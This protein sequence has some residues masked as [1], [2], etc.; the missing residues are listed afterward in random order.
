MRLVLALVAVCL[1]A[2]PHLYEHVATLPSIVD[3]QPLRTFTY[4]P[5]LNRFYAGSD[6]GLF[7]ADLSEPEPRLKGPVVK[8]DIVRIEMAPNLG[9]LFYVAYD[10]I[11][12]IDMRAPEQPVRIGGREQ[13]LDLA[14]EPDRQELYVST[15]APVMQVFDARSGERGPAIE[16]PGWFAQELEAVPGR[17]FFT[18]SSRQGVYAIDA[19]THRAA[20]WPLKERVVTPAHLE[21]DPAGRY[22]FIANARTIY[23]T[24]ASSGLVIGRAGTPWPAAIAFDPAADLLVACWNFDPPP[25]RIAAFKVDQHGL[26]EVG[27]LVNP[28]IGRVG[29]ESIS[30]GFI[31]SGYKALLVWRAK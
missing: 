9:R 23:A 5:V 19:A 17:V 7:W 22:L 6:R 30:R 21:A 26:T 4:D 16:L 2:Q 29:L 11:G 14:Y 31:Q 18:M 3:G 24:D 20:L 15:R 12:Y 8:K 27:R 13:A 10:E 28:S 25:A 1:V